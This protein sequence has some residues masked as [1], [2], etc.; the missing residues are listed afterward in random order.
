MRLKKVK[1]LT[2]GHRVSK[3]LCLGLILGQ[4]DSKSLALSASAASRGRASIIQ[5]SRNLANDTIF[6]IVFKGTLEVWRVAGWVCLQ[7]ARGASTK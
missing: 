7:E 4:A 1:Q 6:T 5:P 3:W 2:Q